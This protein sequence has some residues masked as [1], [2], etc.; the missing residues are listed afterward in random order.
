[1]QAR[2]T[3]T[4]IDTGTLPQYPIDRGERLESH[5]FFLFHYDRYL[6]SDLYVLGDWDIKGIAHAL[7]CRAQDQDPVGTLP[8]NPRLIAGYLGMSTDAWEGYMRK[9]PGPLHGWTQCLVGNE[10]RLMHAVVT[11]VVTTALGSKLRNA[12]KYA[13]DRMRHRINTISQ[14]LRAN[15]PG[16]A[17]IA[18]D[19]EKLNQLSDWIEGAYP[20]GSATVKRIKEAWEALSQIPE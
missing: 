20:G 12:A 5:S 13:D 6:N 18:R 10:V 8:D 15:I 2:P 14:N 11:E 7:W 17:R 3:P 16:G 19:E 4:L 1:M 9:D